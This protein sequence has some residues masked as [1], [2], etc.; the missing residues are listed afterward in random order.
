VLSINKLLILL[1]DDKE[2]E[3]EE[4]RRCLARA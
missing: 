2:G 1:P 3:D 4:E